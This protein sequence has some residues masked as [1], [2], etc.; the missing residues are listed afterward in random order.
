MELSE[1]AVRLLIIFFPGMLATF[2]Y[3]TFTRRKKRDYNV[4]ITY[5]FVTG[6][7]SYFVLYLLIEFLQM[8]GLRLKQITFLTY[9]FDSKSPIVIREVVLGSIVALIIAFIWSYSFRYKWMQRLAVRIKLSKQFHE[10]DVWSEIL[11]ME[12]TPW[13]VIR[14]YEQD[15][16]YQGW[17]AYYSDTYQDNELFLRDVIV[18]ENNSGRKLYEVLGL[19]LTQDP[20]N[21]KIE[22]QSAG[23]IDYE[24]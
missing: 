2:V 1:L 4:F 19:Y 21:L 13:V 12:E 14:D 7:L 16:M 17:I 8:I 10:K 18:Y 6:F 15:R 11:N 22:F 24:K 20:S 23:G 3:D 5:S 9:L